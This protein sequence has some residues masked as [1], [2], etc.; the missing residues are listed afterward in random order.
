MGCIN[1]PVAWLDSHLHELTSEILDH[2][3]DFQQRLAFAYKD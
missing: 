1:D 2:T 3:F